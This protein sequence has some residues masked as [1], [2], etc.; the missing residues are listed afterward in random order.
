MHFITAAP[1][2]TGPFWRCTA[3]A[4]LLFAMAFG[5]G[6][7]AQDVQDQSGNPIMED[8]STEVSREQWRERVEE[9]KR[10]SKQFS[11]E[12][13]ASPQISG[14]TVE[15]EERAASERI[16]NDDSLRSGDI[17]STNKGLFVYT[18]RPNQER[19]PSD[20]VPLR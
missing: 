8:G 13:G 15:E 17:I 6:C 18:G 19:Y 16:L 11:V 9:A 14:S 7:R 2:L 1:P 4:I 5:T 10:R 12:R 3:A 20:F